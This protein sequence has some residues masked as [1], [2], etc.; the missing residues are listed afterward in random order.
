[1]REQY[2]SSLSHP[3]WVRAAGL[4]LVRCLMGFVSEERAQLKFEDSCVV[5]DRFDL[6]FSPRAQ[7]WR[8]CSVSW[9]RPVLK[10]IGISFL[11]RHTACSE[12]RWLMESGFL[13]RITN[14]K[15]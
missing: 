13:V 15:R 10:T 12:T 2:Y 9:R 14:S 3:V 6:L 1:M 7:S 4:P 11:A 5:P 8:E